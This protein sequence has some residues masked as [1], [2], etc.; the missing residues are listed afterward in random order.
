MKT[1]KYYRVIIACG[2]LG[3]KHSVEITRFFEA[4]DIMECYYSSFWT[5]RSKKK[6]D[7]VKLVTSIE[8]EEY[9]RG[10]A[11]ELSNPYL[12]MGKAS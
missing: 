8:Y 10:K 12:V 1:R 2:H 3:H 9:I 5:P 11:S 6:A 7:C 4:D